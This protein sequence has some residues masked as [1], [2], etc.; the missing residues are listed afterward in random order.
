M[1]NR[2]RETDIENK[3]MNTKRGRRVWMNWEIGIDVH[4][5]LIPYI[6]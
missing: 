5:L 2:N 6:K 3:C 4:S 1:Q